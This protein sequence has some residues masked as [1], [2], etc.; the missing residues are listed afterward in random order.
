M[1]PSFLRTALRIVLGFVL[2]LVL[3]G[4]LS[5]PLLLRNLDFKEMVKRRI[6]TALS[7]ETLQARIGDLSFQP[8]YHLRAK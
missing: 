1:N 4:F 2:T 8:F 3:L 5:A 6:E 7:N